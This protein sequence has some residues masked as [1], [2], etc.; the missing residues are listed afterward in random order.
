MKPLQL[1]IIGLTK[2]FRDLGNGKYLIYFIPGIIVAILFWQVFIVLGT[3][4]TS[5]SFLDNIPILGTFLGWIL[6]GALGLLKFI[7][8]QLFV[9]FVL[10]ILSP[11]NTLLSEKV[12]FDLTGVKIK[13]D[14]E[15]FISDLIRMIFIVLVAVILQ[16]FF[17]FIYFIISSILGLGFLDEAVYFVI[18]AFFYG[19]AFYDYNLERD[20]I[21]VFGSLRYAFSN[22]LLVSLT[23]AFFLLL[24]TI[25][26]FF[27][28]SFTFSFLSILPNLGII[29]APVLTTILAT[30]VYILNKQETNDRTQK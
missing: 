5:V 20:Q 22:M 12:A 1:H 21:G 17:F 3:V 29:A 8:T 4:E 24:Y 9:F 25:G 14:L 18:S 13:F 11:F 2:T 23:G 30:Y 28:G 15:R 10:T 26:S 7:F 6:G 19:F 27:V 16:L